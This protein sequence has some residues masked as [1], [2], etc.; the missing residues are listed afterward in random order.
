ML[1]VLFLTCKEIKFR[2]K[3]FSV[4]LLVFFMVSFIVRQL[5]Y[6][7]HGFH[8]TNMIP[9]RFSFLHS[10]VVLYM[11]YKAWMLRSSFRIWQLVLAGAAVIGLVW[12]SESRS[13]PIF[14]AFW[15]LFATVSPEKSL[16]QSTRMRMRPRRSWNSMQKKPPESRNS[17]ACASCASSVWSWL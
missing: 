5:D 12:C 11:A 10:F 8:F 14:L 6:I 3:L 7:W 1:A 16:W 4:A 2:D 15:L 9:Y 13:K 17:E